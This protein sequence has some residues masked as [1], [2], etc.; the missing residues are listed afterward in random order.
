GASYGI[1]RWP[2]TGGASTATW[3]SA[4]A[5]LPGGV[6]GQA[7]PGGASLG[8]PGTPGAGGAQADT[9]F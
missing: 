8:F 4:N 9:N 6:G 3:K 2:A 1:F 7:G 5:F